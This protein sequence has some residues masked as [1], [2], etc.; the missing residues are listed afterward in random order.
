MNLRTFDF[1]L[2]YVNPGEKVEN[3]A[4]TS[5]WKVPVLSPKMVMIP[6]ELLFTIVSGPDYDPI[7]GAI[8][9]TVVNDDVIPTRFAAIL[10]INTNESSPEDQPVREA[11]LISTWPVLK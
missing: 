3:I 7:T 2:D 1:L 9:M 8:T 4:F 11:Y 6:P 10:D 5:G